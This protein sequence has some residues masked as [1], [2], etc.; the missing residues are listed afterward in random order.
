MDRTYFLAER[1]IMF[2][3]YS[4]RRLQDSDKLSSR[5]PAKRVYVC[6][7]PLRGRAPMGLDHPE[8]RHGFRQEA[9][10]EVRSDVGREAYWCH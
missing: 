3:A 5:L 7:H 1:D 9:R 2:A 4:I 10:P 8:R 6:V